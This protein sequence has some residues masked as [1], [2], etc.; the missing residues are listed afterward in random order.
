MTDQFSKRY[1]QPV[2]DIADYLCY[3]F[4]AKIPQWKDKNNVWQHRNNQ[5]PLR[6]TISHFDYKVTSP[7]FFLFF[8]INERCKFESVNLF[9]YLLGKACNCQEVTIET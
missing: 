3:G 5:G 2:S 7:F 6:V 1:G 4:V 8:D 9:I